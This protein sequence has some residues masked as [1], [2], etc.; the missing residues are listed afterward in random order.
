MSAESDADMTP[1]SPGATPGA[2]PDATPGATPVT[3]TGPGPWTRLLRRL[4]WRLLGLA[5][6]VLVVAAGW[7]DTRMRLGALQK[8]V[9]RELAGSARTTQEV[10]DIARDA[11]QSMRDLEF[12]IGMLESRFSESQNQRLALEGL[13]LELSRSRDER[14]LAE[15]EQMLLAGSQ[16]LQLAGNLKAALIALESADGR[17]QRADSTQFTNLRRAIARDIEKLKTAPFLDVVGISLRLD[18][19]A[20]HVY[21]MTLAMF[22][23]PPQEAPSA[24]PGRDAALVRIAREAW[25][26]IKTLVRV[27]RTESKDVPLVAPNQQFF[28]RENLRMR[29]LS[30]RFALLAREGEAFQADVRSAH[31]WLEQYFDARDKRVAGARAALEQLARIEVDIQLPATLESVE[32]VRSE[33]LVR[34]RGL[35]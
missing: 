7:M 3:V 25:Q 2:T 13:Y 21:E 14:V 26:D 15:V 10:R 34:E 31:D 17:L 24:A 28:L 18:G 33:R 9:A 35:R 27:Q 32:A 5:L 6:L 8:D 16:Q 30:A 1:P 11:R 19:I 12:R 4:D 23:R 22:E 29:L 20:H